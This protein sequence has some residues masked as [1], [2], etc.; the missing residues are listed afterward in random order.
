[1][2]PN[3]LYA[4]AV[5]FVRLY[6]RSMLKLDIAWRA[7]LPAG[8]KLFVANHPSATDPFL[9]HLLTSKPLSVMISGNAFDVPL[10]GE[11]LHHCGQISVE[12]GAGRDALE[13]AELRLRA[14]HSV[15]I[16]PEG[17]VSPRGGG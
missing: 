9:I 17:L 1:M 15:G 4:L 11:F 8:P 12:A 3:R 14:G 13:Q 6:A 7:P 16:F 10:F 2:S 5:Q